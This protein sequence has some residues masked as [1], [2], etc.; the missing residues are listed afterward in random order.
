MTMMKLAEFVSVEPRAV[1]A[2]EHGEYAPEE[3]R[4]S[5]ISEVLRFPTAFF[6]GDDLEEPSSEGAS[7]RAFTRMTAG[8]RDIALAAGAIAFS[9]NRWIERHF[10]LPAVD[11]LDG[12]GLDPESAAESLRQSWG[13]GE[14]PIKN[15]IYLLESK[16]I[17]VF[18][19]VIDAKEVDAF[20]AWHDARPFIFLNTNKSAEHSRFDSVHELGHLVLHRHGAP[21]GQTAEKEA[22]AFAAAF[23]M[24]ARS[25][26]AYAPKTPLVNDLIR[27]KKLWGVSVAALAYR[28]YSQRVITEWHYRH[29]CKEIAK[30]GYRK[31]EPEGIRRETSQILAKVFGALRSEGLGKSDIASELSITDEEIES[32]VFRLT[33]TGLSGS[34]AYR[35]KRGASALQLVSSQEKPVA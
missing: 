10:E 20:S 30:S 26:I 9:L 18:S 25:I 29:L 35:S 16:G 17:R 27:A 28:L 6:Y 8:Q 12:R 1:S 33:V 3:S 7:F 4:I 22:N 5:R 15:V 34:S 19:L 11:V 13:L 32:L 14:Q 2:W 31:N 21:Q 23:L 24:P